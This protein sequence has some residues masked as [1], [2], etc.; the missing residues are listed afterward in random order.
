MRILFVSTKRKTNA[1]DFS[2]DEPEN[3]VFLIS[4]TL[5]IDYYKKM[6]KT[7]KYAKILELCANKDESGKQLDRGNGRKQRVLSPDVL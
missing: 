1:P 7:T 5:H 4:Y 6:L 3:H 2:Q